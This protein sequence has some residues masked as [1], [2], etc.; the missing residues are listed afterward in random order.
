[1]KSSR[2]KHIQ[3]YYFSTKLQEIARLISEGRPIINLGIGSPDLP[4]PS[5]VQKTLAEY[6]LRPDTH[7]YQSYRGRPELRE[8]IAGFYRRHYG[9]ELSAAGEILPLI[10]SKEGILHLSMALLDKGDEV[11]IPDPGYMT[12]QSAT[13][14][15][16]AVPVTYKLS[17][18]NN[19][20]PDFEAL[21]NRDLSQVKLMWVNYP[22][23][24]TGTQ[25]NSALFEKLIDFARR[26]QILLIN[27]NPYSFILT[28]KPMSILQIPGAMDV[29]VELNSLSKSHH[30]AGWRIGMLLGRKE[31][32]DTVMK[33]KSQMDSGMFLGMQMAAVDALNVGDDWYENINKIY[34]KRK[35][36]VLKI[37]RQLNL[38]VSGRQAGLFVWAQLPEG[39]NSKA[40]TDRLLYEKDVFVAPGFIFGKN[41]DRYVRFS[42][43]NNENTLKEVLKRVTSKR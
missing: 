26:H 33:F 18:G 12:Y 28:E 42:L 3:E 21:E 14:L 31:I 17:A 24:P 16:E 27:D 29:A 10:G 34:R 7:A 15:A 19:Y 39:E 20:L 1:M 2:L 40:F 35:E 30:M 23:M 22:H 4:P 5:K 37:C 41:S 9:V 36:W 11:L 8:A 32:I 38:K 25:A 43:T 13:L 6:A